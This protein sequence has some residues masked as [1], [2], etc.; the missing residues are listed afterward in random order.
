MVV[1]FR[2]RSSSL[3]LALN[4]CFS[5]RPVALVVGDNS[6]V[7]EGELARYS[8]DDGMSSGEVPLLSPPFGELPLVQTLELTA[9]SIHI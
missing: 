8:G 7:V 9:H 1:V 3:L 6:G 2:R 4:L 5:P